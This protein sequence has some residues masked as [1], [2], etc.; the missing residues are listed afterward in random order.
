MTPGRFHFD[1]F[2][3]DP[4]DRRL[5]RD[6]APVELNARYLDALAL[7]VGE[8]GRLVTKEHFLE[9]VWRGVPVTDEALTQCI[10]TIRR[11]LGDD[12]AR[13][14]F[15]ETVPKHGYRFIAAV[16]EI[17]EVGEAE[18]ETSTPARRSRRE[19]VRTGVAGALGGA[20]AGV[21]GGLFY[22]L[23]GAQAGM[24]AISVLLVLIAITALLG[25]VGGAAVGLGIGAA[26]Q[27]G[28]PGWRR[29]VGG[30][31]GGFMIGAVVKLLGL[32]AF[33]LLFGVS[34][35]DITGATEGLILGGGVGLAV[36][37]AG[38]LGLR[39]AVTV[40]AL[41]GLAAGAALALTG[42]RLMGG[43]LAL[44]AQQFPASHLDLARLGALIGEPSF[45]PVVQ[46]LTASLEGGLF[47][48]CVVGAMRL[49]RSR[50]GAWRKIVFADAA[51]EEHL[52]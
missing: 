5:T 34:P 30:A 20:V 36:W 23:A 26:D 44:L 35:G 8:H 33:E 14:R 2:V 21:F 18:G 9:A 49:V 45:G 27:L 32:D 7:L 42:G 11:Q 52:P 41:I 16:Q 47:T 15:I 24:G 6:G 48:V 17:G 40:A 22:G 13:P 37:L 28:P 50:S 29:I 38:R 25:A 10:R 51:W 46:D 3:L 1:R 4:A 43:S 31:L 12:A 39:L 19:A